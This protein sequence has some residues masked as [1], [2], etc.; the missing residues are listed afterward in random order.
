MQLWTSPRPAPLPPARAATGDDAPAYYVPIPRRLAEDL[1][2][3]PVAVGAFT[4]IARIFRATR[5]P[6][7]LSAGDL[8]VF[9]PTLS[10]SAAARALQ[11]L[12]KTPWV[13]VAPRLGRKAI[14]T[15][16]WGVVNNTPCPW[17]L[18]APCLGRLRH[19][20]A[21][22][23]DQNLLDVCLGRLDP[24]PD[25]PARARRYLATPLLGLREIGAYTLALAGL[26]LP[27]QCLEDLHLV[28]H[29]QP[30]PVPDEAALLAIASQREAHALTEDGWRRTPFG[31]APA[32]QPTDSGQ[33][34]FFVPPRQVGLMI[35]GEGG[36]ITGQ[37]VELEA[38]STAS[39][40]LKAPADGDAPG[41]HGIMKQKDEDPTTDTSAP[42]TAGRG[43][44][45]QLH[46]RT[47]GR[48][49][50]PQD[51]PPAPSE[52]AQILL[53]AGVRRSVAMS[54]ADRPVAQ[55]TRVI[56]QARA[57]ADVRDLAAW[58]V[59]ALRDLPATDAPLEPERPLSALPIYQH[60]GLSDEQRDRWIYRFRAVTTPAEQR[61]ILARLEQEH[62]V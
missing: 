45:T 22:R 20:P 29:G 50:P 54:L 58:V 17:D 57:R 7:P 41:S 10:D 55:I 34:I 36:D 18:Q 3:A 27:C 30:R 1:R 14:Y 44:D 5:Q 52:S 12:A 59:S 38:S 31:V 60:P 46:H 11:H 24:H 9:D 32:P 61:A 25:Y 4:L 35:G 53:A 56:A 21:L 37:A 23:L 33:A 47:A 51:D 8:Q 28:V 62:P 6:V 19:I 16:T 26:P 40:S 49:V 39:G 48:R 15:P 42:S 2:D 13:I 43:G